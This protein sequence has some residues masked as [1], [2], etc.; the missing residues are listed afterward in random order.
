M[1]HDGNTPDS[2]PDESGM[3]PFRCE[4]TGQRLSP[5]DAIVFRGKVLSAEGKQ[6][7]LREL[8]GNQEQKNVISLRPPSLGRRFFSHIVDGIIF[9]AAFTVP[10]I[11]FARYW[12]VCYHEYRWHIRMLLK[13]T[14]FFYTFLMLAIYGQTLG[15]MLCE[16][17]V[18]KTDGSPIS[19]VTAFVRTFVFSGYVL[20]A[21]Y[22]CTALAIDINAPP[23][24]TTMSIISLASPLILLIDTK[25]NRAL[26]DFICHTRVVDAPPKRRAPA[27]H[28]EPRQDEPAPSPRSQGPDAGGGDSQPAHDVRLDSPGTR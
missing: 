7:L 19:S 9:I 26:H 8:D 4:V 25:Y 2:V 10:V 13:A 5:E 21:D 12:D 11:L 24:E 14:G 1:N 18:V 20:V 23:Y 22:I 28:G 16:C 27:M 17:R 3:T 15:K 6:I